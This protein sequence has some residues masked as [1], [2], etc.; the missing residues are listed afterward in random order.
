MKSTRVLVLLVA[1]SFAFGMAACDDPEAETGGENDQG[2]QVDNSDDGTNGT[3]DRGGT[4]SANLAQDGYMSTCTAAM[5]KC[6][7]SE[8]GDPE[9]ACQEL[10]NWR[11]DDASSV[12]DCM[13]ADIA[14]WQCWMTN[15][16]GGD[17]DSAC[18]SEAMA[19]GEYC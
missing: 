12:E 13:E 7:E 17:D 10:R 5:A 14:L 11:R 8:E 19:V 16:C 2:E 18:L 6:R 1:L 4:D 3:D 15:D 9:T